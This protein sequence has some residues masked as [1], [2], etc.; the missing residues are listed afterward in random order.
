MIILNNYSYQ[1]SH[2]QFDIALLIENIERVGATLMCTQSRYKI[3]TH[4]Y[5]QRVNNILKPP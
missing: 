3:C 5:D 1:N 2:L 4:A